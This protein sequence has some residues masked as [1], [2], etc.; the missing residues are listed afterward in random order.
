MNTTYLKR[1]MIA[2]GLVTVIGL[3]TACADNSEENKEPTN[4]T[5]QEEKQNIEENNTPT[6]PE[7]EQN[8]DNEEHS[9]EL[10]VESLHDNF[11]FGKEK[12]NHY[13][14]LFEVDKRYTTD[15]EVL[16][17]EN[18]VE[19]IKEQSIE[20]L[21]ALGEPTEHTPISTIPFYEGAEF[22]LNAYNDEEC[23]NVVV[24]EVDGVLIKFTFNY[25]NEE[26][27]EFI[28]P[29]MLDILNTLKVVQ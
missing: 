20:Q 11:T 15:V 19:K 14:L 27:S 2:T 8:L 5:T 28:V 23:K 6:I 22:F 10:I 4:E 16:V 13:V 7:T 9:Y 12:D 29:D 1:A 18:D 3:T 24:K 26:K 21:K 25:S 17:N